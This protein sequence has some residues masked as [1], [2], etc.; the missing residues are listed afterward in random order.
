[1]RLRGG[2]ASQEAIEVARSE[3]IQRI[4]G[5]VLA[6]NWRMLRA[7]SRLGFRLH[8]RGA[9]ATFVELPLD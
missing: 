3:G 6:D 4:V 7:C 2:P 8:S 1:M 9:E 5:E